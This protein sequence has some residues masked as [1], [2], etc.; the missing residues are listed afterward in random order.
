MMMRIELLCCLAISFGC[1]THSP[2]TQQGNEAADAATVARP[3]EPEPSAG[4]APAPWPAD[5]GVGIL[6]N[7]GTYWVTYIGPA[8]GLPLNADFELDVRVFDAETRTRTAGELA[9]VVDA[10]MPAHG[11]GMNSAAEVTPDADGSFGVQGMLLHMTGHWELYV[12]ITRG[13]LTERA[14]FDIDLE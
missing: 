6:S 2:A 8:D 5:E 3:D 11:H 9:V 4:S 13:P 1:A 12:D 7:D 10:R 14:Q